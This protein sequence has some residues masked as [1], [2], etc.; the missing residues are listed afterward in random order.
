MTTPFFGSIRDVTRF[1]PD[2]P[3]VATV[4]VHLTTTIFVVCLDSGQE[5]PTHAAPGALTL[6]VI[7]GH[8]TITIAGAEHLSHAGDVVVMS[9]GAPHSLSAGSGRAV[10]VGVLDKQP[11][12]IHDMSPAESLADIE[13][14]VRPG[15]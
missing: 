4:A 11:E 7:E 15:D 5:L 3:V 13:V 6:L 10:V 8:V 12:A 14:A 1:D 9:R 2:A